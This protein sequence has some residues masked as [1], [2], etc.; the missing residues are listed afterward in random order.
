MSNADNPGLNDSLK[1]LAILGEHIKH[2]IEIVEQASREY[3]RFLQ[4][5][6][7]RN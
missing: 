6:R 2:R 4:E 5:Y 7:E 3:V 1:W